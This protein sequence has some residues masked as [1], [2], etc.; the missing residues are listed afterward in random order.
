M[1]IIDNTRRLGR[2]LRKR[3]GKVEKVREVQ[4]EVVEEVEVEEVILDRDVDESDVRRERTAS[5]QGTTP[6][7]MMFGEIS[8]AS[9]H[10]GVDEKS[11][12]VTQKKK[13]GERWEDGLLW[14]YGVPSLRA[15]SHEEGEREVEVEKVEIE[16]KERKERGCIAVFKKGLGVIGRR[17]R[18]MF[19]GR[20]V[21]MRRVV[22]VRGF[23]ALEG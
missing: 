1:S 7:R 2:K 21:G 11:L 23:R 5:L 22:G 10:L 17:V 20:C 9:S 16:E 14:Y 13:R 19:L 12:L 4:A 8:P 6:R 3:I 18:G 15:P